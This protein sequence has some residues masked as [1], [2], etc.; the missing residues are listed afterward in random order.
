MRDKI[1]KWWNRTWGSW[2]EV[3]RIAYA[4]GEVRSI[5]LKRTSN[6]GLVQ[7]KKVSL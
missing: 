2:K 6:D 4:D 3:Q 7:L 5:I 1:K